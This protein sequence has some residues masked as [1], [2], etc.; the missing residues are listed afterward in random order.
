M[1]TTSESLWQA[2]ELFV[3][4]R[5]QTAIHVVHIPVNSRCTYFMYIFPE[6]L[7]S[8]SAWYF[9][10]VRARMRHF[11]YDEI[12]VRYLGDIRLHFSREQIEPQGSGNNA[13]AI[14]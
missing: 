10:C 6:A 4:H 11:F 7:I 14:M 12:F 1:T 13:H 2:F 3:F 8:S 9:F 5:E